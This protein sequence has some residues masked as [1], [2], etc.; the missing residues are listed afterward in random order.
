MKAMEVVTDPTD[1]EDAWAKQYVNVAHVF[2]RVLGRKRQKIAEIGCGRGQLTISLAK[3]ARNFRFVLVDRFVGVNYSKNYTVLRR[4]LVNSGLTK[5]AHIVVSDYMKWLTTQGDETYEGVISSEFIPE[6]DSDETS[7][8]IRECYRILK[9]EGVTIHAFLSP[10]PKNFR[11]RLLITA[12]SN[13]LWTNT[14]P[15]E[16]F[17]PKPELVISELRKSGFHRIRKDKLRAQL[18]MKAD[19]AKSWLKSAEVRVDFYEKHKKLLGEAGLE[20]P[21]WVIVSGVKSVVERM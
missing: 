12:D 19:A 21:D 9:P 20:V 14:P 7:R 11:Q 5:R 1:L 10:I 4:N 6:I 3:C 17:S 13:P 15:R 16:W 8:F 18:I 2:A